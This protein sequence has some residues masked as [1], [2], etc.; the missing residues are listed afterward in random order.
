VDGVER[1]EQRAG[2]GGRAQLRQDDAAEGL[3]VAPPERPGC[4][5]ERRVEP[6]YR[7]ADGEQHVRIGEE[8]EDEPGSEEAVDL[9]QALDAEGSQHPLRQPFGSEG[10]DEGVAAHVGRDDERQRGQH[11]EG[12][13]PREIGPGGEPREWDAD[14]QRPGGHGGGQRDRSAEQGQRATVGHRRHEVVRASFGGAHDQVG[15]RDED[16]ERDGDGAQDDRPRRWPS[17]DRL[18]SR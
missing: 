4:L 7:R 15:G 9:R 17:P 6:P 10:S 8:G 18:G 3:A 13:P 5:L 1:D 11:R 16:D 14:R 2:R 12:A